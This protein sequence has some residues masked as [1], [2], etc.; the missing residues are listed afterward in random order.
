MSE[1]STSKEE[2]REVFCAHFY[3][4]PDG[5]TRATKGPCEE[6]GG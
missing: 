4:D 6:G 1:V 3:C 5:E 2:Y